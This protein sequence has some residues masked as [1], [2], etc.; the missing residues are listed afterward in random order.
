MSQSRPPLLLS[1][2]RSSWAVSAQHGT[3]WEKHKVLTSVLRDR[4][5]ARDD[6]TCQACGW[7]S[8]RFQE[9]H[10]RDGDHSNHQEDNLETLCPLCHQT[11]HLPI[12]SATNGGAIIWLPEV[13]QEKLNLLCIGLFVAMRTPQGKHGGTAR[14]LFSTL[15]SR[16]SFVDENLGRSDPG[17]VAQVLLNMKPEDYKRREDFVGPL[18]LLPYS[19]RFETQ[20]DY[21]VSTVFKKLPEDQWGTLIEGLDVTSLTSTA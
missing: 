1:A 12:A 11:F 14:Q 20:I 6:H 16:K 15:E 2:S 8:E 21:W 3:E 17:T 18:R 4:I 7:R 13:S 5:F 10:H 19:A 9:I